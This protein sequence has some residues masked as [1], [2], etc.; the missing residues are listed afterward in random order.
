MHGTLLGFASLG[1]AL[2]SSLSFL[3][4]M[5]RVALTQNRRPF[6]AAWAAALGLGVLALA[7]NPG[8]LG[9]AAGTIGAATSALML[10][11]RA[12]SAQAAKTPSVR[13]GGRILDFSAPDEHGAQ[14]SL[15]SLAGRPF[16]LKFL[17][18]HW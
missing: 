3:Q 7:S 6:E 5:R 15:A 12:R 4:R 2:A 17:R 1:L 13:V 14:F 11:L 9:G 16:L 10:L 8:W 18:G